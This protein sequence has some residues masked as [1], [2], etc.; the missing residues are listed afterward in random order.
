MKKMKI[1]LTAILVMGAV[2]GTL[3]FKASKGVEL[4]CGTASNSCPNTSFDYRIA[5]P[6]ETAVNGIFCTTPA[7]ST[8]SCVTVTDVE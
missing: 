4:K 6:T 1:M 8:S 2:G 3:A 7:G 5:Q